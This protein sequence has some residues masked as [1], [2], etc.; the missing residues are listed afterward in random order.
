MT[1]LNL[2]R[3][4]L[5]TEA[6]LHKNS[7]GIDRTLFNLFD[8]YPPHKF[9]LYTQKNSSLLHDTSPPLNQNV[10]TFRSEFIPYFKNKLGLLLNNFIASLNFQILDWRPISNL[11]AINQFKPNI[12]LIC[13]NAPAAMI[14]GYRLA[15]QLRCPYI[16]YFMDDWIAKVYLYWLSNNVQ[17]YAKK[18][19][20]NAQGWL[21]ISS[22]LEHDLK[23][24]YRTISKRS[25]I[26]HNPVDLSSLPPPD[27]SIHQGTFKVIYAGSIWIMHY[28][29]IKAVAEAIFDLRKE[30]H[31][32]ELVLHTPPFFW[33]QYQDFWE[34]HGVVNGGMIPY[35]D[36]HLHLQKGDLLLVASSF[37]PEL[38]H[39]TRSSVQ[40][41]ITDY[42]A[43]GR[44]ILAC[45]PDYSACNK[46]LTNSQCGM[47]CNS[48]NSS[49]IL[50]VIKVAMKNKVETQNL[51][52]KA[53]YVAQASFDKD[54]VNKG[55]YTFIYSVNSQA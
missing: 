43:S 44:P 29:A 54:Q 40:T 36:L 52:K 11:E 55:L 25:L 12:I 39:V 14:L 33:H 28:D 5:V 34:S 51:A 1:Q 31:D 47:V 38:A 42:M 21:M 16:I 2:P 32:I 22:Q 6:P 48:C 8:T 50:E 46:F 10:I 53:Y 24:R 30:G 4:L 17:R 37:K 27:F 13:P 19:L 20:Q 35:D 9:A 7:T 23:E 26:V 41:K 18:V 45:G 15:R 49:A 3:L